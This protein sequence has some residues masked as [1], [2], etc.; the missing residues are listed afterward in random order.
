LGHSQLSTTLDVYMHLLPSLQDEAMEKLNRMLPGSP[1][2]S[3]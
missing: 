1:S 3:P 2:T